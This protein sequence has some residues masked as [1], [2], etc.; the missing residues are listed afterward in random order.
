MNSSS[1]VGAVEQLINSLTVGK[2]YTLSFEYAF[3]QLTT[4]TASSS[5]KID[6]DFG[7]SV[8]STPSAV[9]SGKGFASWVTASFDFTAIGAS[10]TLSFLA[11]G[12]SGAG[13]VAL[14]DN[15]RLVEK[16]S[17]GTVPEPGSLVLA[18]LG[19][20]CFGARYCQQRRR[21]G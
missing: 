1:G 7:F 5:Q 15:V 21:Q 16:P 4:S 19:I 8:Q 18:G 2:T 11:S 6:V 10:Q 14:I 3:A 12:P 17:S 13:G 9:V 20:A